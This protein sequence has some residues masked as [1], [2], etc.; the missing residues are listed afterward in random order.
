MESKGNVVRALVIAIA[1]VVC[2]FILKSA[3]VEFKTAGKGDGLSA[4]G[5]ASMDFESDLVVWRC[6]FSTYAYDTAEAYA[7]LN[8]Q[9]EQVKKFLSD[10]GISDDEVVFNAVDISSH[11]STAYDADGYYAGSYEDGYDLYQTVTVTSTDID[12]VEKV[13]R[14]ISKLI[15]NGVNLYSSSPEYYCTTLDEVKLELIE[16]A[17]DNAKQRLEIMADGSGC[18]LGELKTANLGVFQITAKNSGTT[19]YAYDGAFDTSS[20]EK[21]ASITVKLNYDV[22]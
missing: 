18:K 21:T 5:S 4:T 9:A 12:K 16:K 8:Q 7:E 17:T 2:A 6:N 1:V 15:A 20:R 3:V 19:Y 14:D 22:K 13:S 10:N 11:Y